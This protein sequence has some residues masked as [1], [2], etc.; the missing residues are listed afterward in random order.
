VSADT[1]RFHWKC[2]RDVGAV[3]AQ[4]DAGD[5]QVSHGH[6]LVIAPAR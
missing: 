6:A 3:L 1:L 4:E 2:D 5:S